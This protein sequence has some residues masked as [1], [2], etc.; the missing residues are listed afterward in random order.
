MGLQ[1]GYTKYMCLLC[2]W[3]NQASEL[4]YLRMEWTRRQNVA[5]GEK[6]IQAPALV[7]AD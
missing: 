2:E 4:R 7:E 3:E 5:V 6:N 1:Q